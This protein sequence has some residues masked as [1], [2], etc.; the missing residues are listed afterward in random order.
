MS[1]ILVTGGAGFLGSNLC[2]RLLCNPN[3]EVFCL[4]NLSCSSGANIK[5][6]LQHKN[7]HFINLDVCD[8]GFYLSDLDYIYHL[9]C[10]ASPEWYSRD[11]IKTLMTSVIGTKNMLDLANKTGAR[12][13]FTSTSEVYGDPEVHP[14]PESYNGNVSI[15]GPRACYDEGKRA[16]ET[17][18]ADYKRTTNVDIRV[19]R[20]FNTYGPNMA[21]ND[22]RVV[23][24]FITQ[25]L[26]SKPITIYGSGEQTRS[27]CYVSDMIDMLWQVMTNDNNYGPMNLG[28][29]QEFTI[30]QLADIVGRLTK[31]DQFI[32]K[33]LPADDPKVR[34]PDLSK[35]KRVFSKRLYLP[36]EDG[37]LKT[38]EFFKH[39]EADKWSL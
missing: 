6:F 11:P 34:K 7:F 13:L 25:A 37:V 21:Y 22:G 18:C 9:A 32:H 24:N 12:M 14:Q 31:F 39:I 36:L 1:R 2:Y 29:D 23:S 17:L 26:E 20:L 27:F 16:A 28:N 15:T 19:V 5:P 38:I 8:T 4:D 3:N 10:P 35:Y 30:E 33:D